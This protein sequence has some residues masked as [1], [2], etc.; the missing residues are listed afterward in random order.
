MGEERTAEG[1]WLVKIIED[2]SEEERGDSGV[3]VCRRLDDS[4]ADSWSF[5]SM[6]KESGKEESV[7]HVR[8]EHLSCEATRVAARSHTPHLHIRNQPFPTFDPPRRPPNLSLQSSS[9]PN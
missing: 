1:W 8:A 5:S 3:E 6:A 4:G 7:T 2:D 9:Q